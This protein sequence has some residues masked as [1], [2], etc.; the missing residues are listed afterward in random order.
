MRILF[1][2]DGRSPT[3][4]NWIEYFAIQGDDIHLVSLFP[5]QI[6]FGLA[7]LTILPLRFSGLIGGTQTVKGLKTKILQRLAPPKIR[8]WIRHRFV[9]ASIP[10]NVPVLRALISKVR[11][12]IVHAMRIPYEG[13]L[14]AQ[15]FSSLDQAWM[16]FLISV[17]GNDFTLHAPATKILSQLTRLT[18][19]M[20]DGLHADCYR[21]QNLSSVWGFD[22]ANKP[23]MVLPGSGGIQLDVFYPPEMEPAPVVINPRGLRVY[24]RNDTFFQSVPMVLDKHPEVK[25]LCPNMEGQVE[26]ENWVE[27]LGIQHA[28]TLL[29]FQER[30]AMASLYR[31]ASIVVSPSLHDGTPNTLLEAMA[32]GCFPVAGDIE[33]IREWINPGVNGLVF[34]PNDPK[35]L[36]DNICFA[37]ENRMLRIRAKNQNINLIKEKAEYR[38]SM[39]KAEEFYRHLIRQKNSVEC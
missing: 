26:A 39:S 22:C 6:D 4:L 24:V 16:P 32:C 28:T 21:D 17:W 38:T 3:A 11:P 36:A 37:L 18:M 20:A 23:A 8:T 34:D 19:E 31:Q 7:S 33:T 2:A 1:V 30:A 9:P 27:N 13:M 5:C 35:S 12:D 15:T 29:P 25:F 10:H 14:T